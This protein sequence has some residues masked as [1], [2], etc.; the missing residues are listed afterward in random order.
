MTSVQSG[1]TF[2]AMTRPKLTYFDVAGSRGEECRLALFLAGVDFEDN[3]IARNTWPALKPTTPFGNVPILEL[4]GKPTLA[5][6]NAILSLVGRLHGL[7]PKDEW[8]AA[9][10]LSLMSAAEDLRHAVDKTIGIKDPEELKRR[11]AELVEGPIRTWGANMEKQIQGPFA[12]GEQISVADLKLYIV[13]NWFKKGV[14]DHVPKDVLAPFPK[15]EALFNAV[16]EHPKVVEWYAR[17]A[18]D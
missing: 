10:H 11:R 18:A 8:E 5:Q 4:P 9:R 6:S 14:L 3:R 7:L 17:P 1:P 15:L 16:K 2:R 13:M 12:G